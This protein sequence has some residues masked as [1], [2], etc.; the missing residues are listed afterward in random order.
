MIRE[1]MMPGTELRFPVLPC[2]LE[3]LQ[4]DSDVARGDGDEGLPVW[5]DLLLLEILRRHG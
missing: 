1:S 3:F 5:G 2:G 4:S